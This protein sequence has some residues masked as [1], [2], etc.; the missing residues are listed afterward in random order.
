[1]S[2]L[3][4][5]ASDNVAKELLEFIR[6]DRSVATSALAGGRKRLAHALGALADL[7]IGYPVT[8]GPSGTALPVS[9]ERVA[10]PEKGGVIDPSVALD[11]HLRPVF[12]NWEKNIWLPPD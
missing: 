1:M 2:P 3:Q 12:E 8:G 11:P 5:V 6:P 9:P 7:Q 4:R 10:L